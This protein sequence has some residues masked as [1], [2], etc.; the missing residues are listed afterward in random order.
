MSLTKHNK[1]STVFKINTQRA[2]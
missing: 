1:R 2:R